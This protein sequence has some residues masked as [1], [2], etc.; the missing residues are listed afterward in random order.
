M[1]TCPHCSTN[2][3]DEILHCPE[4]GAGLVDP[5]DGLLGQ[6][7]GSYRIVRPL[8]RGGMGAV[9]LAEHP[10]IGSKVAIKFL[11]Q[12]FSNDKRIVK[13]FFDEAR[14]V[15]IIGHDNILRILDL[16][17]TADNQHYFVMEFLHGHS[18][19]ALVDTG[20]PIPLEVSGPIL[21]QCCEALQAAHD[22]N[23]VH[24]DLKPENIYLVSHRGRRNFVKLVDFGIAKLSSGDKSEVSRTQT[25]MVMGTPAY[26]S[27]EQAGGLIERIDGRSD[28]YSLGVVFYQLATGRLPFEGESFGELLIAHLQLPPPTPTEFEPSI[29]PV[30]EA[31][32]LKALAKKQEDRFQSMNELRDAIH[33]CLEE[34]GISPELPL[35]DGSGQAMPLATS[36]QARTLPATSSQ[37]RTLSATSSQARTQ[38]A[39]SQGKTQALSPPP[40]EPSASV[41]RARAASQV[42][43]PS[44]ARLPLFAAAIA[45]VLL[46]AVGATAMVVQSSA[47]DQQARLLKK[48]RKR[49]L[50]LEKERRELAEREAEERKRRE[51][52]SRFADE[53]RVRR[54]ALLTIA[55]VALSIISDPL[56]AQVTA[57]WPGKS[58]TGTTPFTVQAPRNSRVSLEFHRENYERL[59]LETQLGSDPR[60]VT[61]TLKPA[62]VDD[63][64]I[65]ELE[66]FGEEKK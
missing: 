6:T 7:V 52:E 13:R 48:Q 11:H 57:R 38:A 10:V 47:E 21:L 15:N 61:G 44:R 35:D 20:N 22:K 53:T 60:M 46:L 26:M 41:E 1:K 66:N 30:L 17:S 32:L 29:P 4:D 49:E 31:I 25:G 28:V 56:G 37:A 27:P 8:G 9:Y 59:R 64:D 39:A 14:A 19:Q 5:E 63:G 34:L 12:Q 2:Y 33:G 43:R 45:G 55:P 18:L 23:I 36:S 54:E 65:I 40:S 24:R 3:E 50:K 42:P 58:V 62:R 16:D 51:E